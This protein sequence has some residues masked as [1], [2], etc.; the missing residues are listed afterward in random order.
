MSEPVIT[1][2]VFVPDTAVWPSDILSGIADSLAKSLAQDVRVTFS[3]GHTWSGVA[4]PVD[5]SAEP[6]PLTTR[7]SRGRIAQAINSAYSA[8]HGP[9]EF[10]LCAADKVLALLEEAPQPIP[11]EEVTMAEPTGK[12]DV[13][14][15]RGC[16]PDCDHF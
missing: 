5:A 1:V 7:P 11:R 15:V 10:S 8:N 4:Y 3:L 16:G 14:G 6:T 9:G 13:R 12:S 2:L